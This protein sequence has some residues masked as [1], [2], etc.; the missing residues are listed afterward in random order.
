[1]KIRLA[2]FRMVI[3]NDTTKAGQDVQSMV[4]EPMFTAGGNVN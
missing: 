2:L 4:M 1:M 3:T